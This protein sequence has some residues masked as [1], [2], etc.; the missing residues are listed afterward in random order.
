VVPVFAVRR[1]I[2]HGS[3]LVALTLFL[4][5]KAALAQSPEAGAADAKRGIITRTP[6]LKVGKVDHDRLVV[7]R[8][9]VVD[10]RGVIRA[11]LAAET[12]EP[13]VDGIQYKRQFPVAGLL[14]F[15]REGSERG[16]VAVADI[17][18]SAAA[19]AQDHV[20]GDAIGWRVMPDGSV[21]FQLNERAPIR[22][23]PSLGGHM[24]A[25]SG[26]QR[27]SMRVAADGTPSIALNDR[28][29]RPRVRL[30]VTPEGLGALEF[31][32]AEGRVVQTLAPEAA[33][34][35]SSK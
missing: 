33:Q 34:S 4:A 5:A 11:V 35:S 7:R 22:R 3:A 27:I 26:P 31:L 15:D 32:D 23:D 12:P 13:I 24:T 8:I 2:H 1:R 14:L 9:D 30:T 18:G 20:N 17:E 19:V 29:S 21:S 10:E 16:G 25:G 6:E 28:Q